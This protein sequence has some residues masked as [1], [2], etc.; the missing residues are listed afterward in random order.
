M[1][2][3]G[4]EGRA[5]RLRD[6]LLPGVLRPVHLGDDRRQHRRARRHLDHFHRGAVPAADALDPGPDGR[7]DLVRLAVAPVLVDEVHLQVAE[8][9]RRAQVVLAHEAVEVDRRGGAGVRLV[10][11]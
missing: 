3:V 7:R 5:D 9:R 8:L 11:G 4:R 1:P 10:V 2:G 6:L